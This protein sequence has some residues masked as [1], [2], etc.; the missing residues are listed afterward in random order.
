MYQSDSVPVGDAP[1]RHDD[2]PADPFLPREELLD[3]LE[4]RKQSF[5][6][7]AGKRYRLY[8]G[9][10]LTSAGASIGAANP[11]RLR[12]AVENF[13]T[14]VTQRLDR[15]YIA[16]LSEIT[17]TIIAE[18]SEDP[19]LGFLPG[20]KAE[21]VAEGFLD[22]LGNAFSVQAS[23]TLGEL[24]SQ[25]SEGLHG[26]ALSFRDDMAPRVRRLNM[27]MVELYC[28]VSQ[29]ETIAACREHGDE[30]PDVV[31]QLLDA[32]GRGLL[33]PVEQHC[34]IESCSMDNTACFPRQLCAPVLRAMQIYVIGTEKYEATN[35][36]LLQSIYKYCTINSAFERSKLVEYFEEP[37][38]M[39]YLTAY[40][41]HVLHVLSEDTKLETFTK[42][43]DAN[44]R[45]MHP[46]DAPPFLPAHLTMLVQ[47]WARYCLDNLHAVSGRKRAAKIIQFHLPGTLIRLPG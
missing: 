41:V 36:K 9:R 40:L 18:A 7:T 45:E 6:E 37:H 16:R 3:R 20:P 33:Y 44:L 29:E 15:H 47:S 42:F 27:D 26:F 38:V 32:F 39:Q 4:K 23:R 14:L 25:P 13:Q 24:T 5:V 31:P 1:K 8:L 34:G 12:V 10:V 22:I 28:R 46:D 43:V 30:C 2:Q 21:G 17:R 19:E 35:R 11:E